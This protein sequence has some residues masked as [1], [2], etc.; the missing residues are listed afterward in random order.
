MPLKTCTKCKKEK[1]PSEF[2][3]KK[4]GLNANCRE[5][6]KR[7]SR[8]YYLRHREDMARKINAAKFQ[9][10]WTNKQYVYNLLQESGCADCGEKDPVVLECD[11]VRDKEKD[12][13]LLLAGGYS[14]ERILKEIDKCVIRCANCHRRKTA[15]DQ[16]WYVRLTT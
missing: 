15:K 12:V 8:D 14:L 9:R 10:I 11:H 5:C 4:D 2:N 16:N 3:K 6:T 1:P 13:S 7:E